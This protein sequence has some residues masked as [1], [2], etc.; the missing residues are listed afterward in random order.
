[1]IN[2]PAIYIANGTA[3][4]LLSVIL[5]SVKKPLQHGL[6]KEKLYYGMIFLN[7]LLCCIET[8]TFVV[9]GSMAYGHRTLSI[10]LNVLLFICNII[11]AFVWVIYADCKLFADMK[12]IR[13]IYPFVALP[14]VLTISACFINLAT[15]V[16]FTIDQNNIYHRTDLFIIPYAVTYFYLAYGVILIYSYRKKVEKYLFLPAVLFMLPIIIGS[17][18]QYFN[19]G[20]SL[21]WLGTSIGMI[22]LFINV[23]HE[24]SYVDALSGLFNR[25]HLNNILL[26]HSMKKDAANTLAGIMLDI[27]SFASINNEFGHAVGD[28]AI[29]A[30]GKMLLKAVGDKGIVCRY[31]GDEFVIL[32]HVSSEKEI[33][34]MID[35]IQEQEALFNES[36]EI[37]YQINFS[38]GHSTYHSKHESISNFL[39]KIDAFMYADK[40]RKTSGNKI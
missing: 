6:F 16:F 32:M 12:R 7:M 24:A 34:D 35:I 2:Y 40:K 23:Q 8:A 39:K 1:M 29:A 38:I 13:R 11:F 30:V 28:H 36:D 5:F 33:T 18:L 26:T 14:A 19:Y 3:I 17:L 37:P 27:D 22:A 31:G 25:Q 15:P 4:L 9:D 10:A 20:Y 21:V